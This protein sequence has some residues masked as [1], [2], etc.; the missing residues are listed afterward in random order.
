MPGG[1]EH[2]RLRAHFRGLL[3]IALNT[4]NR[5]AALAISVQALTPFAAAC[6][7]ETTVDVCV[8]QVG[9]RGFPGD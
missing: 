4:D 3:Q 9:L 7:G 5:T 2:V 1:A 6:Y 8:F